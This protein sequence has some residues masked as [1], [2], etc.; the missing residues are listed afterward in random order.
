[1]EA[2][3]AILAGES[4]YEPAL[5]PCLY[6]AATAYEPLFDDIQDRLRYVP[7][8]WAFRRCKGC[9]SAILCPHPKPSELA[10]FYPPIYSFTPDLVTHGRFRRWFARLEYQLLYQL[11]YEAQA[12]RVLRGVGW[13]GTRRWRLLDVGCGRGLRLL[14]FRRRGFE[15]YGMD[16]QA[17][18]VEYVNKQLDIP[19]VCS[20]FERLPQ[21]FPP[22]SFDVTTAFHVLEHVPD[23]RTAVG[24][25][26]QLLKPGGWLVAACPLVDGLQARLFGTH[27]AGVT[28]APRHLSLP[29]H[30]GFKQVCIK[31]GYERAMIQPDSALNCAGF[32][33]LS[34]LPGA[35]TT[36]RGDGR[37]RAPFTRLVGA[38]VSLLSVPWCLVENHLLHRPS[39]GIVFAQKPAK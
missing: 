11:H 13:D 25:C 31:A 9:G 18:D 15:V 33:G 7:G 30:E 14:A 34:L 39:A 21:S 4:R 24:N 12:R 16:F 3:S 6:C 27:W 36:N 17:A 20:N 22:A 32:I 26:F 10:S 8:R 5:P 23:V 28:E 29:S 35:A 2:N 19:A 38:A 1:M 37:L